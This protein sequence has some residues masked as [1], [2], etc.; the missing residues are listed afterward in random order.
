[1]IGLQE[2]QVRIHVCTVPPGTPI[3]H[4]TDSDF[5]ANLFERFRP[6]DRIEIH[7][8][9]GAFFT[10]L[11]VRS[12]TRATPGQKARVLVHVLRHV[13]FPPLD[14]RP[15]PNPYR[16]LFLGPAQGWSVVRAS[17]ER[18]MADSLENREIAEKRAAQLALT[19]V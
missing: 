19:G 13:E 15:K 12:V 7:A 18:V 8:A 11:Y 17:D 2:H 6:A 10:E 5:W 4:L 3:E 1:M 16:V 14:A 9:D